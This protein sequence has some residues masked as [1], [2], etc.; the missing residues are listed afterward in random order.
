[1]TLQ[2]F[3]PGIAPSAAAL[4]TGAEAQVAVFHSAKGNVTLALFKY[5]SPQI[6]GAQ[7]PEFEKLPGAMVKRS[8]PLVAVILSPADPDLAERVLGQVRYQAEVT[9]H[10]FVPGPQ[11][12]PRILG[13]AIMNSF[14]FLGIVLAF[15]LLTGFFVG[16]FRTLFR[17]TKQ[18][19]DGEPMITLHL[20]QR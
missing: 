13:F 4:H 14:V 2:K 17:R 12:N 9:E 10:E 6:A 1:V 5:P 18:G 16:S 11:D 19:L 7:T 8:G 15:A 20:E 3:E